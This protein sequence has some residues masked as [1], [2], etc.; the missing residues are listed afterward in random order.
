MKFAKKRSMLGGSVR[1]FPTPFPTCHLPRAPSLLQV[2][3]SPHPF[4]LSMMNMLRNCMSYACPYDPVDLE[5]RRQQASSPANGKY[6]ER[7]RGRS[8]EAEEANTCVKA[9]GPVGNRSYSLPCRLSRYSITCPVC[10][11]RSLR[12]KLKLYVHRS[13]SRTR[14]SPCRSIV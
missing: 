13:E 6:W 3:F 12:A 2:S 14:L 1:F 8:D 7:H 5:K 11:L 4:F 9:S 10:R